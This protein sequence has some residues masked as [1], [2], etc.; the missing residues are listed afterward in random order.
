MKTKELEFDVDFIGEQIALT[1]EEDKALNDYFKQRKASSKL[2]EI[3]K[4][5]RK[6]KSKILTK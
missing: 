2:A 6:T 4:P 1:I 3:R 5:I